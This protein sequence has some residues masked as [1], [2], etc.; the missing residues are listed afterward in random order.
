VDKIAG[1][2]WVIAGKHVRVTAATQIVGPRT[3]NA[4]ARVQAH[5][6]G[7]TL[8]ADH[9]LLSTRAQEADQVEFIGEV[10]SVHGNIWTVSGAKV[11]VPAGT[12][13]MPTGTL[14]RVQGNVDKQGRITVKEL[15]VRP[16]QVHLTGWIVGKESKNTWQ[17]LVGGEQQ[18]ATRRVR[19]ILDNDTP[20]DERGGTVQEGVRIELMGTAGKQGQIH[21][22][23]VRVVET[24]NNHVIGTL[25][26]I[27]QGDR[28]AHPWT[29]DTTPVWITSHTISDRPLSEYRVGDRVAVSGT[30]RPDGGLDAQM[31][32]PSKR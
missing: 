28:F 29:V 16:P 27:P 19:V 7:A 26:Y 12:T 11:L 4:I 15:A 21:A 32:S 17:V 18:R 8:V 10:Q 20:I 13:P 1:G 3:A 6:E 14:V 24:G 22:D 25:T 31:I 2:T 5:K 9:I 23:F 30:R